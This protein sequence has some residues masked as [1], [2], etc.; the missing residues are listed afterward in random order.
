MTNKQIYDLSAAAATLGR[1]GGQSKS[2]AKRSACRA[3]GKKGGRPAKIYQFVKIGKS[4]ED[5]IKYRWS[6]NKNGIASE[7]NPAL[8]LLCWKRIGVSKK[9]SK[10]EKLDINGQIIKS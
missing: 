1:K 4:T 10:N 5:G 7:K 6:Y 3:N 8:F 2:D 9:L